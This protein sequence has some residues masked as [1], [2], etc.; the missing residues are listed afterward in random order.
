MTCP[1]S[2]G[3]WETEVR[4][5]LCRQQGCTAAAELSECRGV[6]GTCFNSWH[7][8]EVCCTVSLSLFSPVPFPGP[9]FSCL[10]ALD[11]D[12]DLHRVLA[13][14]TTCTEEDAPTVNNSRL[15]YSDRDQSPHPKGKRPGGFSMLPPP[16]GTV[17]PLWS[18]A[19]ASQGAS[20]WRPDRSAWMASPGGLQGGAC[21]P[22]PGGCPSQGVRLQLHA[23][24]WAAALSGALLG[25]TNTAVFIPE[26]THPDNLLTRGNASQLGSQGEPCRVS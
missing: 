13:T 9:P 10:E 11:V 14:W 16:P 6:L 12:S 2:L 19:L 4:L 24:G 5:K 7:K 1:W 25:E 3:S 26:I 8:A 23:A 17:V 22:S 21:P 15:S 18:L 20:K